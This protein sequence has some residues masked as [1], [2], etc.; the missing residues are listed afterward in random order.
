M[1]GCARRR[2]G[3]SGGGGAA[4]TGAARRAPAAASAAGASGG[5]ARGGGAAR[6]AARRLDAVLVQ[7]SAAHGQNRAR[8]LMR[9]PQLGQKI[10]SLTRPEQWV[11]LGGRR[12][13]PDHQRHGGRRRDF[14]L[15]PGERGQ[16]RLR[17]GPPALHGGDQRDGPRRVRRRSHRG[18]GDGLPRRGRRPLVQLAD[19]RPARRALRVRGADPLDRVHADARGR[20]RR[21]AARRPARARGRRARRALAHRQL[22]ELARAALQRHRSSARSASTPRCAARGAARSRS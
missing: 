3:G 6:R 4:R 12:E 13:G 18:R 20:L 9:S 22:D 19:P 2:L 14:A 16:A 8:A 21:R 1:T 15:G 11:S 7:P 17:G 5:G 10:A